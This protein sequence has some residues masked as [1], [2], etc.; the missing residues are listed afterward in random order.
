MVVLV[1]VALVIALTVKTYVLQPFDKRTA[2]MN[3]ILPVNGQLVVNKLVGRIS[4]IHGGGALAV[5]PEQGDHL[6]ENANLTWPRER[7]PEDRTHCLPERCRVGPALDH[8]GGH[9]LG[10]VQGG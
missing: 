8:E 6:A 5:V 4:Q 9:S 2:A 1:V 10:G 7:A 3:D